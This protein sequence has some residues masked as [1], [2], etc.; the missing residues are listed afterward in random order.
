MTAMQAVTIQT[1]RE[2]VNGMG[3]VS[4]HIYRQLSDSASAQREGYNQGQERSNTGGHHLTQ[5]VH[6]NNGDHLI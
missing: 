1:Y 4:R 5:A 2:E 3:S 6:G